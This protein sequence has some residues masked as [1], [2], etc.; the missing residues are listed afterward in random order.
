MTK[1]QM[2]KIQIIP[3]ISPQPDMQTTWLASLCE[4]KSFSLLGTLSRR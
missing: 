3:L 2:A 4:G 1:V